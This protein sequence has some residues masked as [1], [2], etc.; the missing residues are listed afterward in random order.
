L[1]EEDEDF[2]KERFTMKLK[3]QPCPVC[4][5]ESL[6]VYGRIDEIPHFGEVMEQFIYCESCGYRHSDVM[7]LEDKPPREYRYKVN[8]PEDKSVR[9]VRSPTGFIEIPELGIE[10]TPGPAAEGFV[11]NVE[12]LLNR[13]RDNVITAAGW[14]ETEEERKRAEEIL[15][16]IDKALEGEDEITVVIKDPFGHSAIL[17]EGEL[18]EKLEVRELKGEELKELKSL[19]PGGVE[20][21]E[22]RSG[23]S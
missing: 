16:R 20:L 19:V 6:V 5:S 3:D 22:D 17:P 9:V 2:V 1:G 11:S 4:G 15:E 18:E 10:V 23:E 13:I 7:C 8:A 12:G 21:E 14:A